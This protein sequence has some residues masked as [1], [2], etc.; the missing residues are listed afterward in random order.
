M[1]TV[2]SWQQFIDAVQNTSV[3]EISLSNNI[4]R[5]SGPTIINMSSKNLVINGNGYTIDFNGT[6]TGNFASINSATTIMGSLAFKDGTLINAGRIFLSQGKVDL[7]IENIKGESLTNGFATSTNTNGNDITF[8]GTNSLF[9]IKVM[10]NG[11]KNFI[12]ENQS[13]TLIS[14]T[15]GPTIQSTVVDS[16]VVRNGGKLTVQNTM[17]GSVANGSGIALSNGASVNVNVK[18]NA[19]LD[20]SANSTYGDVYGEPSPLLLGGQGS[21]N[22]T[23]NGTVN[24][25]SKKGNGI[26]YNARTNGDRSLIIGKGATVNIDGT[27]AANSAQYAGISMYTEDARNVNKLIHI[28]DG[29]K[30]NIDTNGYRGISIAGGTR[31]IL[32]EGQD[33]LVNI[34]AN[35]WAICNELPGSSTNASS[36]NIMDGAKLI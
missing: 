9:G 8:K 30:V 28:K 14:T 29:A 35:S 12:V 11:F 27:G 6:A 13:D 19:V 18:E 31:K 25:Y 10:L 23:I 4:K 17:N 26:S 20:V 33:T 7:I 1:T 21:K 24:T 3:N 34:N 5:N 32:V 22:I 36:I 16:S 2:S 15:I